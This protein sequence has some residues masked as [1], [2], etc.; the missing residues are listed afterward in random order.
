MFSNQLMVVV[1][2]CPHVFLQTPPWFNKSGQ[3]APRPPSLTTLE[4]LSAAARPRPDSPGQ[5][6]G[7]AQ[8]T[9]GIQWGF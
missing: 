6:K 2:A 7:H 3:R 9:L 5:K 8:H 4:A 1:D